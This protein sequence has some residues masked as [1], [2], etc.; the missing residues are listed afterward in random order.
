MSMSDM[1]LLNFNKA[2]GMHHKL[3]R[4]LPQLLPDL[5]LSG[6][7][8]IHWRTQ[9]AVIGSSTPLNLPTFLNCVFAQ[10]AVQVLLLY[11]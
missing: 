11:S 5:L 3:V 4:I 1:N 8:K 2:Q 7:G 6:Q 10:N 9:K